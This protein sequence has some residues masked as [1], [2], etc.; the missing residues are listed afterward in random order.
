MWFSAVLIR[1][2][3][4]IGTQVDLHDP[5]IL[6]TGNQVGQQDESDSAAGMAEQSMQHICDV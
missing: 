4:G 5:S 2:G 3:E 6:V 1:I